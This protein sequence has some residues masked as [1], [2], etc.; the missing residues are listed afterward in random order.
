MCFYILKAWITIHVS[1][2]RPHARGSG[3]G[4]RQ[5]HVML[6]S[7]TSNYH[8]LQEESEPA[9][10]GHVIRRSEVYG[11]TVYIPFFERLTFE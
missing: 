4:V 10:Y 8:L 11:Q 1:C 9:A 6:Y 7:A 5:L 3:G 2:G